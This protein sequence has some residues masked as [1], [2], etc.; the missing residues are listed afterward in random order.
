MPKSDLQRAIEKSLET[1]PSGGAATASE[2]QAFYLVHGAF[3]A[4]DVQR[5]LGDPSKGV[6]L[7]PGEEL[8]FSKSGGNK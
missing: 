3:R 2:M 6:T 1:S 4:S 7:K 8:A 5:F